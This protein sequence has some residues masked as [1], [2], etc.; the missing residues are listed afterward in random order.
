MFKK[1]FYLLSLL[2]TISTGVFFCAS[3]VKS[4][5]GDQT[6]AA[7]STL[8]PAVRDRLGFEMV[9]VLSGSVEM[10][11]STEQYKVLFEI[12][13]LNPQDTLSVEGE[14]GIFDTYQAAVD[15]FWID[16][17]EVTI[18]QYL[19]YMSDCMRQG[20][21]IKINLSFAKH[22]M[23]NLQKPQVAVPWTDALAFCNF[24]GARLPTEVEW[25][26]AASGP[27]NFIFPWGNNPD[28]ETLKS[29]STYPV[30]TRVKNVSWVG[31]YDMVGNAA[32]WVENRFTPYT[33]TSSYWPSGAV[34]ETD[35]VVRGGAWELGVT[36]KT[37]YVRDYH[38]PE[39]INLWVGFRCARTSKP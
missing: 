29:G 6:A 37:T 14:T 21:C 8:T 36:T 4:W 23:D 33:K 3:P 22:L 35:R 13:K 30:G 2:T 20:R 27:Q 15:A 17:Y 1:P 11:I 12:L 18:D 26:Y 5:H 34:F 38:Q 28:L 19:R 39:D 24:R 16:K 7:I 25:E 32:E 9:Y 31:A 10:G